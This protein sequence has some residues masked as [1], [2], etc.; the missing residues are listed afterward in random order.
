MPN[1]A[2]VQA[3]LTVR[4]VAARRV[5]RGEELTTRYAGLN[6][7]QPRRGQLLAQHWR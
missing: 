6:L 3:G 7:G 2:V 1:T 5:Q 4:V